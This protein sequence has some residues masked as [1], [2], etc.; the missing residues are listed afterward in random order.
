MSLNETTTGALTISRGLPQAATSDNV[1]TL[2]LMACESFGS[3]L[4]AC[5]E[6]CWNIERLARQNR[7][8]HLPNFICAAIGY[9]KE[10]SVEIL[11]RSDGSVSF[12]CLI[13]TFC[14][15]PRHEAATRIDSLLEATQKR[16]QLRPTITRLQRLMSVL[17]S[18]LA[19]GD[20]AE[21]VDGCIKY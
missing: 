15:M 7:T 13:A 1:S 19:L 8:S 11:P 21:S 16:G 6:T 9:M 3:L 18:K 20:F 4:P 14:M 10:D 5:P 2:A 12:L 17:E